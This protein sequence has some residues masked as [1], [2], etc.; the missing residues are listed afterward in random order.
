MD[1]K[2][3]TISEYQTNEIKMFNNDQWPARVTWNQIENCRKL[4]ESNRETIVHLECDSKFI[5]NAFK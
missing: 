2:T 4:I 5:V 3:T 1:P